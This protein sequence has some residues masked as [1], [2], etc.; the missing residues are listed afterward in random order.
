M[1]GGWDPFAP[2]QAAPPRDEETEALA[3]LLRQRGELVLRLA[4]R[5]LRAPGWRPGEGAAEAAWRE[6]RKEVWRW[7]RH[8]VN[9][10]EE[11]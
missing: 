1:S 4:E 2:Q 8:L 10:N 5:E 9:G 3:V 6:G 11:A 7:L